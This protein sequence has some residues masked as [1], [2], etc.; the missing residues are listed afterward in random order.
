M[1]K[2]Y[3]PLP[4]GTERLARE[5]VDACYVVH[6]EMGPGLL[7]SIYEECLHYELTSR[8][9][10]VQRQVQ[11]PLQ[12]KG[13]RLPATLRLDLMVEDTVIL[14]LKC[15]RAFEPVHTAQLLSY[16][17]LTSKRL[18][19]LLNFHVASFSSGIKRLIL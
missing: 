5:I 18:G 10:A 9:L 15:V 3:A 2:S 12:F 17:R 19:F 14:E 4:S 8:K 6:H 13:N 7:E 16:L 1:K 11:V